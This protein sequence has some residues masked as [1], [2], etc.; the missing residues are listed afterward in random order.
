MAL[1]AAT[2]RL[3]DPVDGLRRRW[4]R[5]LGPLCR[6][7]M[8]DR[9]VRIALMASLMIVTATLATIVLP[10]W[11][12][13][14]GPMI[15]GVPHLLADVRYLVVG[16][17]FHRRPLLWFLGG[18]PIL[19]TGF[20][21]G[22]SFGLL[23]VAAVALVARAGLGRRLAAIAVAGL[24]SLGVDAIGSL[25]DLIF[26]YLHNFIAV[27]LWWAW[28]PRT[29]KL[30]WIPLVLFV[31]VSGLLLSPVGLGLAERSAALFR[32]VGGLGIDYQL[33]RLAPGVDIELGLRLVLLYTFTQSIH[34]AVWV[35]LL[36]D[37]DRTRATPPTFRRSFV[38]LC[39]DLGGPVMIG[40]AVLALFF[41]AWAILDLRD[42]YSGYFRFARF[43]G[44][45]ELAAVTLLVLEGRF[46][47]SR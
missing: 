4:L 42:A 1:V 31:G 46:A 28:R 22:L 38:D 16:Q 9:D 15:W 26:A 27:A 30:H 12:L 17:G 45:L 18:L 36:P 37:E 32:E 13:A 40:A 41:A 24:L 3:L 7:L 10:L 35:H 5:L 21:A 29:R 11:V 43:H 14:I 19:A 39:R 20:G 34:Y 8:V 6:P 25:A 47:W 23:G 44:H 2:A 33:A